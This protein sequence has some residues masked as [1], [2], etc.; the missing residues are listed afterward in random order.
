L[1]FYRLRILRIEH[2]VAKIYP[3]TL[4]FSLRRRIQAGYSVDAVDEEDFIRKLRE[5]L[6]G[7]EVL[8]AIKALL[9]QSEGLPIPAFEEDPPF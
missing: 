4:I 5:Y 9:V 6:G 7:E 8:Q 2:L 1:N 3:T